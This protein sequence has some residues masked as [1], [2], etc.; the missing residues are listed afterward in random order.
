MKDFSPSLHYQKKSPKK[1]LENS[2]EIAERM[3]LR[4]DAADY[5]SMESSVKKSD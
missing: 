3:Y 5:T 4:I 2:E 1:I